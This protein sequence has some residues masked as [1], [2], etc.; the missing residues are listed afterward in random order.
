ML[1]VTSVDKGVKLFDNSLLKDY[2]PSSASYAD[3]KLV[4]RHVNYKIGFNGNY[5]FTNTTN[6]QLQTKNLMCYLDASFNIV[7][8]WTISDPDQPSNIQIKGFEDVR[9]YDNGHKFIAAAYSVEQGKIRQVIGKIETFFNSPMLVEFLDA[10]FLEPPCDTACEKNWIPL[11]NG[12]IVYNWAPFH[13]GFVDNN[14]KLCLTDVSNNY[15]Q[16]PSPRRGSTIP[17]KNF[18]VVHFSK[19]INDK[20]CYFHQLLCLT[21]K[22]ITLPFYFGDTM[23]VQYCTGFTVL[24]DN[25]FVFWYSLND[26]DTYVTHKHSSHFD[27]FDYEPI[28]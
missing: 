14:Y 3:G 8:T 22:K 16:F 24:D 23:G 20:H 10:K 19:H 27:F 2:F 18:V 4:V 15:Y 6:N 25:T 12:D 28:S 7:G 26:C 13:K 17:C 9:M 5:T 11:N 1:C 21:T